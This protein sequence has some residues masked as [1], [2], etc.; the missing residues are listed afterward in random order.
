M[1]KRG[2]SVPFVSI[3]WLA[4]DKFLLGVYGIKPLKAD[5]S[6]IISFH[7]RRYK[8]ATKVLNDGSKV[9]T[10][11]TIME[12]HLNN[13]WFKR[14]RKLNMKATQSTREILGS[15]EQDLHFIAQQMIDGMFEDVV[16]LHATTLLHAGAKRLGFQVDELPDSLWNKGARFY[17]INLMR[18]YHLRRDGLSGSRRKSWELREVWLSKAALLTKYAP[19]TRELV[20]PL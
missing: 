13:A 7:L 4:I 15:F 11:D 1:R 3:F 16:A 20:G 18:V 6:S 19:E 12:L 9:K 2:I 17:M 14:R 8:G 10:G 5:N